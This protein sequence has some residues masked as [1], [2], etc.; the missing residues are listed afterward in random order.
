MTDWQ[1]A[2]Q[3]SVWLDTHYNTNAF[4]VLRS[5]VGY[6]FHSGF[7]ATA[8]YAYALTDP[9]TGILERQEHRPWGQFVFPAQFGRDWAFSERIRGELRIRQKMESGEVT[10]G[11]IVVPRLRAQTSLS[12]FFAHPSYGDWFAQPGIE[13]LVQGGDSVGTNFL[14]SVRSSILLGLKVHPWTVR[15]GYMARFIPSTAPPTYEHDLILWLSYS[16]EHESR[17]SS[18]APPLPEAQNP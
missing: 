15:A 10:D 12:W 16:Y 7:S 2:G 17:P 11:W 9:G 3:W 5:G 6:G 14:D 4:F 1:L 13:L 8:G 18:K